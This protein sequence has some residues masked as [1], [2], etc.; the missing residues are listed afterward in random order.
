MAIAGVSPMDKFQGLLCALTSSKESIQM[1]S[2]FFIENAD[3]ADDFMNAIGDRLSVCF[4]LVFIS[5]LFSHFFSIIRLLKYPQNK[6]WHC[7]FF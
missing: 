4:F 1:A 3:L 7:F 2:K 6:K 5:F